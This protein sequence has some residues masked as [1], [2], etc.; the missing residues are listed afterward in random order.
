MIWHYV[1]F[2]AVGIML[3]Y[4]EF[5]TVGV[6]AFGTSIML[7]LALKHPGS[8]HLNDLALCCIWRCWHYVALCCIWHWHYVAFGTVG[9][10]GTVG[11]M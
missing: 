8:W 1:A 6:V 4:V 11:I 2:G 3:H 7:H 10:I 5:G 9:I